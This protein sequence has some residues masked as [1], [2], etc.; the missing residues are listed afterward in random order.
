V[1]FGKKY[2]LSTG[3]NVCHCFIRNLFRFLVFQQIWWAKYFTRVCWGK[4]SWCI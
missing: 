2:L 1:S 3:D 4:C